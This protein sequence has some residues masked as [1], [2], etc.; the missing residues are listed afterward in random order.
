MLRVIRQKTDIPQSSGHLRSGVTVAVMSGH[1]AYVEITRQPVEMIR[2][3]AL[4]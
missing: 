1:G 3:N 2:K 4:A